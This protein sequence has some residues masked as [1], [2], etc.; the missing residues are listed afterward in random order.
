MNVFLTGGTGYI[1]G[2]VA[3]ELE[4]AGHRVRPLVHRPEKV[5]EQGALGREVVEGSLHDPVLLETAAR[6]ADAVIHTASTNGPD[7][8]EVDLLAVRAILAG[9]NGTGKLFIYT[10]GSWVYGN[11]GEAMVDE[12]SPLAPAALVAW[13][14]PVEDEI[15]A[16]ARERNV[17]AVVI[18]PTIVYGRGG[19]IPGLLV[20][21]GRRD[22]IVRHVGPSTTRWSLVHVDDLASLYVRALERAPAGIVLTAA[23]DERLSVGDI[24]RA[25]SEAAGYPGR[26]AEWPLE[27]A[28]ESMGPFADALALTQ[29][30]ASPKARLLLGWA[31]KGPSLL[32]DLLR[33]SY[34]TR[35]PEKLIA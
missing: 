8:G 14:V 3:G 34:R 18:R 10:S 22:G 13:R 28:R 12:T 2:A 29:R 1:G 9:L 16:A 35:G 11:T 32:E 33:G 4:R 5:S 30:V 26:V 17:R 27:R 19:G 15:L 23:S 24:A 7:A 25:A 31:P 20:A 6:R 21:N